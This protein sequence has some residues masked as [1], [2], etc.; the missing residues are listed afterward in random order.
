MKNW[1]QRG[2]L[3]VSG[4]PLMVSPWDHLTTPW[5]LSCAPCFSWELKVTLLW[6]RNP[7]PCNV[8]SATAVMSAFCWSC[9]K[10]LSLPDTNWCPLLAWVFCLNTFSAPGL[11]QTCINCE[12]VYASQHS[13]KTLHSVFGRQVSTKLPH[14]IFS[15]SGIRV[16]EATLPG[17]MSWVTELDWGHFLWSFVLHAGIWGRSSIFQQ[18]SSAAI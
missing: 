10:T 13:F 4:L 15:W 3:K 6:G 8:S 1:N 5:P 12:E 17:L 11:G 18:Q 9:R 7:V 16:G 14:I 2:T